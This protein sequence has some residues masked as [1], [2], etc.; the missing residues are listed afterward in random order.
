MV[1]LVRRKGSS[2]WYYR[3]AVPNDVRAILIA[4][5]GTSRK[6]VWRSLGTAEKRA[7]KIKIIGIQAD[8]HNLWN[9]LRSTS[10]SVGRAPT[11]VEMAEVA[12]EHVY[13]KFM[14]IQRAKLRQLFAQEA[15]IEGERRRRR[16]SNVRWSFLPSDD[17]QREME[18]VAF[19][20]CRQEGWAFYPD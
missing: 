16:D 19:A 14:N 10:V 7:A 15:D 2:N 18:R 4:R 1:C 5:D 9:E 3:E 8:Q 20:V 6:E 11:Q 13:V 17:D 12:F